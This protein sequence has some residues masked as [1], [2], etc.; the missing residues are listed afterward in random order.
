M[1]REVV[2]SMPEVLAV[3]SSQQISEFTTQ[4]TSPFKSAWVETNCGGQKSTN[5]VTGNEHNQKSNMSKDEIATHSV[6]NFI[7]SLCNLR[8]EIPIITGNL[9]SQTL[10]SIGRTFAYLAGFYQ[11]CGNLQKQLL[12]HQIVSSGIKN[13][14][15][16]QRWRHIVKTIKKQLRDARRNRLRPILTSMLQ[17]SLPAQKKVLA[18]VARLLWAN[19]H[20][21]KVQ[22][23][24]SSSTSATPSRQSSIP[25]QNNI[26]IHLVLDGRML[27]QMLADVDMYSQAFFLVNRMTNKLAKYSDVK[28]SPDKPTAQTSSPFSNLN[29]KS[30]KKKD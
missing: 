10:P 28:S 21:R 25:Q 26:A 19:N 15:N 4:S 5:D 24:S 8:I 27:L 3:S 29:Q 9:S 18:I 11:A 12:K 7:A 20:Y 13:S 2:L 6:M 30:R 14:R 23:D 16:F 1:C 17:S 22:S